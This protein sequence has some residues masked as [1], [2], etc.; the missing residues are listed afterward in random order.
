[1]ESHPYSLRNKTDRTDPSSVFY[2]GFNDSSIF[3][4][5]HA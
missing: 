4:G 2:S 5:I 1:M 3:A